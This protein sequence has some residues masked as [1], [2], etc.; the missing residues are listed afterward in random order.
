M[1]VQVNFNDPVKTLYDSLFGVDP[2]HPAIEVLWESLEASS[3]FDI[4]EL[5]RLFARY[6][7]VCDQVTG[8]LSIQYFLHMPEIAHCAFARI[9]FEHEAVKHSDHDTIDF[10]IFVR[11][12]SKLS[13][14]TPPIE[15]VHYMCESLGSAGTDNQVDKDDLRSM[16]TVLNS[17]TPNDDMITPLVDS[18]WETL[19]EQVRLARQHARQEADSDDKTSKL[20]EAE[21]DHSKPL[22]HVKR[23]EITRYLCSLDMQNFLTIQF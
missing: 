4:K 5:K 9:A 3:M 1:A 17:C 13:L 16:L 21:D 23:G 14:K 11:I 22:D 12:L 7:E 15:K 19:S 20:D 8:E 10:T 18:A 6:L 2:T